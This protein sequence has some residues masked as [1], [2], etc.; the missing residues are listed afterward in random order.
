MQ[1]DF[2]IRG[3]NVL[4]DEGLRR[5]D[6]G[7][8]RGAIAQLGADL[9]AAQVVDADG[10]V[11][12]PGFVDIHIHGCGGKSALDAREGLE[13]MSRTLAAHGVTGFCPT[14]EPAPVGVMRAAL[15]AVAGCE[16]HPLPGA[17]SLGAH[18]EGPF[19]GTAYKGAINPAYYLQATQSEYERLC[20]VFSGAVRRMTVDPTRPGVMEL[21]PWLTAQGV[22]VS[23]GHTDASSELCDRAFAAGAVMCTH[24]FNGMAPLHHRDPHLPGAALAHPTAGVEMIADLVHLDGHA[25]RLAWAAKGWA[26]TALISDSM[27]A[28]GM[29]DGDYTL[30]GLAVLVRGG[31]AR[32][33]EGNLAGST[34]FLD[35]AV[36]NMAGL[37]IPAEQVLRMASQTPAA[38]VGLPHAL[39]EGC[40]AD[41]VLLDDSLHVLRTWVGGKT[42]YER[43]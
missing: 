26:K 6:V 8:C 41:L 37:A 2:V 43:S 30:G 32:I 19:L 11:L 31:V 29:P 35:E 13:T 18:L 39:R 21:I 42:V 10:A 36:R 27:A 20:G 5:T 33:P 16:S 22:A 28:A 14:I 4:T 7:I 15:A 38:L 34:L 25:L 17:R 23:I 40:P 3:G 24:L 12:S 9:G 1:F